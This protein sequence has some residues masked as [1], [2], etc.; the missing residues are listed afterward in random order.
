[1]ITIIINC[2]EMIRK[3]QSSLFSIV[4]RSRHLNSTI[5]ALKDTDELSEQEMA[6]ILG[7][8]IQ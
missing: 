8:E 4:L 7:T 6:D 1:M 3:I 2:Q 5:K